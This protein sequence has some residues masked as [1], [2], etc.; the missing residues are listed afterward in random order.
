MPPERISL[1][2][3]TPCYG[4]LAHASCFSSLL[5][6]RRA[7]MAEG[8]GLQIELGGG[9]ALIG[10]FRASMLAVFL[11]T[12][13]T[14]LLF[15]DADVGFTPTHVFALLT[16]DKPVVGGAYPRKALSPSGAAQPEFTLAEGAAAGGLQ[17]ALEV[18]TGFLL[19][20]RDAAERISAAYPDLRAKLGDVSSSF[21]PEAVMVFD[22]FVDPETKRYLNDYQ[23]FCRRWRDAGGDL[24]VDLDVRA[25]HQVEAALTL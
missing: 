9:E 19:I 2:V 20:R 22:S 25:T 23:A 21:A 17:P 15:A 14:H 3:A 18:G 4:G 16:H 13:A 12:E 5:A 8:V 24:W 11:R 1:F 7:C 10:R 6:L